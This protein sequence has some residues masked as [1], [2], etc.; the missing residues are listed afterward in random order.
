MVLLDETVVVDLMAGNEDA[1]AAL[2]DIDWR[3]AA[4]SELTVA[5]IREGLPESKQTEFD[6]IVERLEVLPYD[7]PTG[8]TAVD[9]HKRLHGEDI[10]IDAVDAMIAG[11]AI[12][13]DE[14][15]LTRKPSVFEPTEA[16]V[17]T[18]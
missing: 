16:D 12:E 15:V 8:R 6:A 11:T 7:F 5:Q 17:R 2:E 4:V 14:P 3:D 10:P 9:E 13:A 1:V 18:Y